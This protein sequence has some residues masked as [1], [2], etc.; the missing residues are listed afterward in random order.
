MQFD[1]FCESQRVGPI[2]EASVYRDVLEQARLADSLGF[3]TWWAVEHHGAVEYSYSAAPELLLS[4]IATQTRQ[5]RLGHAGVLA[6]FRIN[7]PIRAAERAAML[8]HISGGRVELGLARSLGGEWDVFEVDGERTR[9]QLIEAMQMIPRMWTEDKFSWDSPAIKIP[10]RNIIPKP[11]QRPHPPLWQAAGS[12]ASFHLAGTMGV[13]VHANTLLTGL[14]GLQVLLGEYDRGISE[15]TEPAGRFINE[16]RAVFT[17]VHVA[18]SER[19]AID[20]GAC[21]AA[22]WYMARMPVVF[23]APPDALWNLIRGGLLPNDPTAMQSVTDSNPADVPAEDE[24][25]P[26][27]ELIKRYAAGDEISNEEAYEVL[28]PIASVMVGDP[29]TCRR[30]AEGYRD[31]GIDH[32]MCF[33]QI[34]DLPQ[35]KVLEAIS[36]VGKYLIPHFDG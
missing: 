30:K 21:K 9:D 34:A 26:A 31:L 27:I 22:L 16:Q 11:V 17:F 14:E 23:H 15:C 8:D 10:E 33:T 24:E 2:D 3:G 12:P 25:L 28:S 35:E 7:H 19:A 36:N 20:S 18:E 1:I 6:P 13:G 4:W 32:L 5:I 29:E